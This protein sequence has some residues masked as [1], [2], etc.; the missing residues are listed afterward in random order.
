MPEVERKSLLLGL[1]LV[2]RVFSHGS[3]VFEP[4]KK[5]EHFEISIP[6]YTD[7]PQSLVM[8]LLKLESSLTQAK[9]AEGLK[10]AVSHYFQ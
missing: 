9:N 5:I 1:V 8:S 2:P 3:P 6:E 10:G 4:S 7:T